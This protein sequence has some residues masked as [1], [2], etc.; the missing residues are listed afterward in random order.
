MSTEGREGYI[1]IEIHDLDTVDEKK[2]SKNFQ[3]LPADSLKVMATFFAPADLHKITQVS[4][5]V[6]DDI[7]KS[8]AYNIKEA[9]ACLKTL[10]R[11]IEDCSKGF[12]D[13]NAARTLSN[14]WEKVS[15]LTSSSAL[16]SND[17]KDN[18]LKL[19]KAIDDC[20][21]RQNIILSQ[22]QIIPAAL[23][24]VGTLAMG[25]LCGYGAYVTD[26]SPNPYITESPASIFLGIA[27][28]ITGLIGLGTAHSVGKYLKNQCAASNTRDLFEEIDNAI[29]S[30]PSDDK[31]L[32]V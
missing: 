15:I 7:Y 14:L 17:T 18:L 19:L 2:N 16:F 23:C 10:I 5:Q 20:R 11:T 4:K 24:S 32:G 9:E 12:F 6:K 25:A 26:T 13:K 8:Q 28:G 22:M 27:S 3:D 29:K 30:G 31:V 21:A 1:G